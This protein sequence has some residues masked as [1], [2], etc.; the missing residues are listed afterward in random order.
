MTENMDGRGHIY[1]NF[2]KYYSF[3]PPGS[4]TEMFP[5]DLFSVLWKS[6]GSPSTFRMLDVGCN[7]GDLT[8][9]LCQLAREQL[10]SDDVFVEAY[11]I[12]MDIELIQRAKKKC[13]GLSL[14]KNVNIEFI[15]G[16]FMNKDSVGLIKGKFNFV[17]LFSVTMWIHLNHGDEGLET[18]FDRCADLL[19]MT[20]TMGA[21]LVEPQAWRSYKNA[22]K[23]VR[24]LQLPEP[25][26]WRSISYKNPEEDIE[27]IIESRTQFNAVIPLGRE[28]WGRY[29]SIYL[30][31][32]NNS[33]VLSLGVEPLYTSSSTA[34][35]KRG[36][37][38]DVDNAH[39]GKKKEK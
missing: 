39:Q 11:G 2:H 4:R 36:G 13:E 6:Q 26:F 20:T 8:I 33:G 1:G 34:S 3:H 14:G 28:M 38:T 32:S 19:S 37:P 27:K 7:E 9:M 24:N 16:D 29:C 22:R 10:S 21:L 15:G 30:E 18:L 17:S 35:K 5:K 31:N 25:K 12:D 23:R